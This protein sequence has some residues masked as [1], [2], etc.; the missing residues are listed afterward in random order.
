MKQLRCKVKVLGGDWYLDHFNGV[1]VRVVKI[2]R[3]CYSGGFFVTAKIESEVAIT[4]CDKTLHKGDILTANSDELEPMDVSDIPESHSHS[5]VLRNVW[6]F[7]EAR[8]DAWYR[9]PP[10][11]PAEYEAEY[12]KP[13][14]DKRIWDVSRR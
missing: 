7:V 2:D 14:E 13:W 12:G 9:V 3:D 6:V 8:N 1:E 10:A 4:V 5:P 11:N